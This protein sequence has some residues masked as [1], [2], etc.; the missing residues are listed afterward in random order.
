MRYAL[1]SPFS[2]ALIGLATLYGFAQTPQTPVR[3]VSPGPG[4]STIS[5]VSSIRSSSSLSS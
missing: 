5:C 4:R 1:S 3:F 2:I